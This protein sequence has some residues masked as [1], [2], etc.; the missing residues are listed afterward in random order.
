M[1]ILSGPKGMPTILLARADKYDPEG[2]LAAAEKAGAKDREDEVFLY[3]AAR[4]VFD[5]P[6]TPEQHRARFLAA[7]LDRGM[8]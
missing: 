6:Q 8:A 7:C 1:N 2:T 3:E 5:Q 4:Q